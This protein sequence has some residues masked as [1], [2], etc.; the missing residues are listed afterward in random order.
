MHKNVPHEGRHSASRCSFR[1]LWLPLP[2]TE[3]LT[4]HIF[5]S[6]TGCAGTS[7]CEV[8]ARL[9]LWEVLKAG[10]RNVWADGKHVIRVR[11][12]LRD[13][14]KLYLPVGYAT[15]VPVFLPGATSALPFWFFAAL[16]PLFF[17]SIPGGDK[18]IDW[19][20]VQRKHWAKDNLDT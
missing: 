9:L 4:G 13:W 10:H 15:L 16:S 11:S 17:S 19:I 8:L 3:K 6:C 1:V 20:P 5:F 2:E 12:M 14:G 7:G 18:N